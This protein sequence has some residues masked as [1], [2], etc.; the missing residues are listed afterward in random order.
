M[1]V[2]VVDLKRSPQITLQSWGKVEGSLRRGHHAATNEIVLLP[3][4]TH[5]ASANLLVQAGRN[6]QLRFHQYQSGIV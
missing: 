5:P 1:Q 3:T 6:Q 4:D 2:P